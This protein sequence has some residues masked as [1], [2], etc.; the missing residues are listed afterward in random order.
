MTKFG[1]ATCTIALV[2]GLAANAMAA[3]PE[4]S[5][6]VATARE[7]YKAGADALDAGDA[8]TALEKLT[9][10]WALAQ[11]PVIGATLARAHLA[12][13]HLVDARESALAVARLPVATNETARS[14][15]ARKE[16]DALA[17]QIATRIPHVNL[18]VV[19]LANHDATVKLDGATVPLA[20][21]SVLR[22]T[23]QGPHTATVD[24]DDGR[25]GEGTVTVGEGE[26]KE[27]SIVVPALASNTPPVQD[28]TPSKPSTTP[29]VTPPP[30]PTPI[31]T[32]SS[33]S[34]LV[35]IGIAATGAGVAVGAITGAFALSEAST[36]KSNCTGVGAD[37]LNYCGPN[38][39]GDLST[40]RTMATISTIGFIVAGVG[41]GVL[42]TGLVL[43]GKKH[44]ETTAS[45]L[46]M[47]GPVSGFS[48]AF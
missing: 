40:A 10:A 28:T 47:I 31:V 11:T 1:S 22:Q 38:Y 21:L 3:G 9:A 43:S 20:A 26:T 23:K 8:K 30:T 5:E 34:P 24:T 7:L 19:G 39:T 37:K 15:E 25:H 32:S 44:T 16:A 2:L 18:K 35:W 14:T 6:N 17:A 41:V 4:S 46:P 48:G 12:V 45:V 33:T 29:V 36:V 42:V 13:G 27:L